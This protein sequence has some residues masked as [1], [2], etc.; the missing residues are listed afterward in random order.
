MIK[1]HGLPKGDR[2]ILGD[3]VLPPR[4]MQMPPG[5]KMMMWTIYQHPKDF[6]DDY[7]MR[8]TCV[9]GEG[10]HVP[11]GTI[12]SSGIA[13]VAPTLEELREIVPP[14]KARL[15]RTEHDDPAIAEVWV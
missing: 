8:A 3:T 6:P 9:M 5:A 10:G 7:V 2:D 15:E 12:V 4:T 14:D 13:W 1:M 11:A